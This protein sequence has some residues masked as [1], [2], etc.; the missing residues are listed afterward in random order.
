MNILACERWARFFAAILAVAIGPISIQAA[1]D[2][3]ALKAAH[4]FDGKS[5][6]LVPN[7]VVI[8]RGDKIVDVGSNLA[9][10]G[11]AHLIDLGDATLAP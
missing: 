8:V 4:I 2:V 3:I 6:T 5:K 7:G 10:P 9:V 11:D 1:D